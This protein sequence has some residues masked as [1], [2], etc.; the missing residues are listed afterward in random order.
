MKTIGVGVDLIIVRGNKVLL[1]RVSEKWRTAE[2]EWG[3]PGGDL[4]FGETFQKAIERN[5]QKDL[6]MKFK[7]FKIVSVNNNFWLDNHYINIG[8]LAEADGEPEVKNK[9]DWERWEWFDL[10]KL[11]EKLCLPAKLT[12]RSYLENKVSVSE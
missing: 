6:G 2:G 4:N 1:G 9:E 3:P 7:S 12:L 8:V 5:L 10:N 11:P